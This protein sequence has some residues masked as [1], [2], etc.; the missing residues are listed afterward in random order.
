MV[1]GRRSSECPFLKRKRSF[2]LQIG[3]PE[4][5]FIGVAL[6]CRHSRSARGAPA[7]YLLMP[8]CSWFCPSFG[9]DQLQGWT[10][11]PRKRK[12]RLVQNQPEWGI[13]HTGICPKFSA[14][15][16][17]VSPP[18]L[19]HSIVVHLCTTRVLP[20]FQSFSNLLCSEILGKSAV[21][22]GWLL[23]GGYTQ[24]FWSTWQPFSLVLSLQQ[25]FPPPPLPPRP[26][27]MFLF[28]VIQH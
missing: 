18:L 1:A 13:F 9:Y 4:S 21:K 17:W 28:F 14:S 2:Q 25:P 19:P 6:S 27:E 11:A 23:V 8:C 15:G 16:K 20:P 10:S 24:I 26:Q 22:A 7:E 12:E 3:Q 5:A